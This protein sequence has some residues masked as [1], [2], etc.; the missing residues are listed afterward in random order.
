MEPGR[1]D[2]RTVLRAARARLAAAGVSSPD[3]DAALLLAE[4]LGVKRER[5]ALDPERAL[6]DEESSRFDALVARRAERRPMAQI[7]GRAEFWSL[8]FKVT[9][10]TLSPRPETEM[11]VEEA[12]EALR[13][14]ERP[15]VVDIGTGTGCIA[16]AIAKEVPTATI[17][18]VD[19]SPAALAVARENVKRHGVEDRVRLHEGSRFA[20][21]AGVVAPAT[22]DVVVSNPPY[23]RRDEAFDPELLFEPTGAL[24]VDDVPLVYRLIAIDAAPLVRTGGRII[25]EL[26]GATA[27]PSVHAVLHSAHWQ[28]GEVRPDLGGQP[29]MLTAARSAWA[30]GLHF[31]GGFGRFGRSQ[32]ACCG[33]LTLFGRSSGSRKT[34]GVCLWRDDYLAFIEPGDVGELNAVSLDEA[35]RSYASLGACEPRFVAKSR[36]PR[37]YERFAR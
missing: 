32:C 17:H 24:F 11:L 5:L 2:V 19:I 28:E 31:M 25:L 36:K 29:R 23:V 12:V 20:P 18:A 26:P 4:T 22:V 34:C 6:S 35:R 7:L 3:L 10:D 13:G 1:P 30:G 9:P 16:V 37:F 14:V 21:L 33:C 15:V 27:P 8:E